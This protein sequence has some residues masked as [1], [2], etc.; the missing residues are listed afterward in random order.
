MA[1]RHNSEAYSGKCDYSDSVHDYERKA[2]LGGWDLRKM[3]RVQPPTQKN[4]EG[5]YIPQDALDLIRALNENRTSIIP[6]YDL[7]ETYY[8]MSHRNDGSELKIKVSPTVDEGWS[9]IELDS[10]EGRL[11]EDLLKTD[12][13]EIG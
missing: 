6:T 1:L 2:P 9:R 7:P 4:S 13:P 11:A 8:H 12:F 10:Q 3:L 5:H